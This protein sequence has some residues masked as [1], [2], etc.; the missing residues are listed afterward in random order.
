MV[1]DLEFKDTNSRAKDG[2][3]TVFG[4]IV[5]I[6]KGVGT[7]ITIICTFYYEGEIVSIDESWDLSNIRLK[8]GEDHPFSVS[9]YNEEVD[10][11][12]LRITYHYSK[13][14]KINQKDTNKPLTKA[15]EKGII[16]HFKKECTIC[17]SKSKLKV[18][19]KDKNKKNTSLDNLIVLCDS[20]YKKIN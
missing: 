2:V 9:V 8:S 5:N 20:C 14:K 10:N 1:N 17:S 16:N 13:D 4:K 3:I 7:N 19:Y 15:E 12:D 18:H 6:G 11:Y